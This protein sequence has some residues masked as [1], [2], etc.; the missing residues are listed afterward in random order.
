MSEYNKHAA[1]CRSY[2]SGA[3]CKLVHAKCR[4]HTYFIGPFSMRCLPRDSTLYYSCVHHRSASSCSFVASKRASERPSAHIIRELT[5]FSLSVYSE[6]ET[7]TSFARN[8]QQQPKSIERVNIHGR[9]RDPDKRHRRMCYEIPTTE[10]I[11][12]W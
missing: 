5:I 10:Y 1:C 8:E 6:S 7:K 2:S 11:F 9:A 3:K 12:I 4:A